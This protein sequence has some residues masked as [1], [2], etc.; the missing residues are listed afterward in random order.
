VKLVN[1]VFESY[2]SYLEQKTA[3]IKLHDDQGEDYNKFSF[4]VKILLKNKQHLFE[5]GLQVCDE[6]NSL[7][8]EQISSLTAL[9]KMVKLLLLYVAKLD[10]DQAFDQESQFAKENKEF[11]VEFLV[12]SFKYKPLL[13][14]LVFK[15]IQ[16]LLGLDKLPKSFKRFASNSSGL[17]GVFEFCLDSN[18]IEFNDSS[19][20]ENSSL[21]KKAS[22]ANLIKLAKTTDQLL[23]QYTYTMSR[24]DQL[25]LNKI[26]KLDATLN[27][28]MFKTLNEDSKASNEILNKQA[29]ITDFI[30]LKLEEYK[31]LNTIQNYPIN[32]KLTDIAQF[33]DDISTEDD[34]IS[35][36]YDPVYLLPNIFNLLSYS[37]IV[38]VLKFVQSRCLSFLFASLTIECEQLRS[39][40]YASL[41]LFVSHLEN[42]HAYFKNIVLYLISLLR[43]SVEKEN[44]RL[45]SIISVFLAETCMVI[46]EPGTTLYKPIV[47]FLLLKP[48]LD[49]TNVPEFYKLFN[50]SS[51][52]Y[53][54]ERKMDFKYTLLL[55]P[56][57]A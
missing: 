16:E 53:K 37:N 9:A 28:L 56:H 48:T 24:K 25:V 15:S 21:D 32:R 55:V 39:L 13:F 1:Y 30:A 29:K 6:L 5:A 26:Y 51:L 44:Q 36:V 52:Q 34:E 50:S 38:D 8:A 49:L 10:V 47:Q 19:N 3:K 40:A 31:L 14:K 12:R 41:H 42:S 46:I 35:K 11:L 20:M 7:E 33:R 4:F 54:T 27:V 2:S 18:T 22:F 45:P 57:I 23:A 43:M 17:L